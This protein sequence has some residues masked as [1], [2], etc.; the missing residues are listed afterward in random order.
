MN[1]KTIPLLCKLSPEK[2]G[3]WDLFEPTYHKKLLIQRNI[4]KNDNY[5]RAVLPCPWMS[6]TKWQALLL[7][8]G[9][10]FFSFSRKCLE[11]TEDLEMSAAVLLLLLVC[12]EDCVISCI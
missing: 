9:K 10:G 5:K 11:K 2:Y 8:G 7:K 1:D 3:S 6:M 12:Y 4:N